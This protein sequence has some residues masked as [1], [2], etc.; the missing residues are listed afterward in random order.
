MTLIYAPTAYGVR[1]PMTQDI[2]RAAHV[3]VPESKVLGIQTFGCALHSQ[4]GMLE[5][6]GAG[7]RWG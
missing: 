1:A 2:P 4:A 3:M 7:D 5:H 6:N